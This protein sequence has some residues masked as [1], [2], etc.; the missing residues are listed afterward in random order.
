MKLIESNFERRLFTHSVYD[1]LYLHCFG[2][3]A[4]YDIHGFY[5]EQFDSTARQLRWFVDAWKYVNAMNHR[6]SPERGDTHSWRD[7]ES[8]L[9]ATI[10]ERDYVRT[11]AHRHNAEVEVSE[12]Q[13]LQALLAR[14]PDARPPEPVAADGGIQL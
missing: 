5:A 4:H 12:R 2:H 3:I 7:V 14:Y 8:A 13:Q 9:I 10:D 1:G 6:T 11:W